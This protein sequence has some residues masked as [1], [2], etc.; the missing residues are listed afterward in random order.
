MTSHVYTFDPIVDDESP[1]FASR[2]AVP[3]GDLWLYES[4]VQ[5]SQRITWRASES[6]TVVVAGRL[7]YVG[8]PIDLDLVLRPRRRG[9]RPAGMPRSAWWRLSRRERRQ[10]GGAP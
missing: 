9:Q 10:I 4:P 3:A 1:D 5:V 6:I 7:V 8:P 2:L